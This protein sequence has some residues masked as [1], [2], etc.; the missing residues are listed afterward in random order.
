MGLAHGIGQFHYLSEWEE[1]DGQPETAGYKT[2]IAG[3]YQNLEL[4]A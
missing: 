3:A 4:G 2:T 1:P